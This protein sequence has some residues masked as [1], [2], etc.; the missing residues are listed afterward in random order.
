MAVS[1][2]DVVL[3]KTIVAFIMPEVTE[4]HLGTPPDILYGT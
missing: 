3:A 4:K 1:A 2:V